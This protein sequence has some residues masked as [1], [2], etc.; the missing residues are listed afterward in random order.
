MPCV[1]GVRDGTAGHAGGTA[2]CGS[3][4]CESWMEKE[5]VEVRANM[6]IAFVDLR[7]E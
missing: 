7:N 6:E 2:F 3:P 1:P 5:P 4:F